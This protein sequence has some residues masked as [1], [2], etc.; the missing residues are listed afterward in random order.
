MKV[1]GIEVNINWGSDTKYSDLIKKWSTPGYDGRVNIKRV[2]ES[3]AQCKPCAG[4]GKLFVSINRRAA[5]VRCR[6][7]QGVGFVVNMQ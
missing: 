2:K 1:H 4:R 7:C 3:A 5:L 6:I